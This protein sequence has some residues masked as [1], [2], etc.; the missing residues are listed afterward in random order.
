MVLMNLLKGSSGDA[1]T[2]NRLVD[3]MGEGEGGMT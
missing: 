3:M 1:G 2:E